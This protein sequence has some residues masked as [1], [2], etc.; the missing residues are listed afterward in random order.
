MLAGND[1]EHI[2]LNVI[3]SSSSHVPC[4][5]SYNIDTD[6]DSSQDTDFP[7]E[8]LV[9]LLDILWGSKCNNKHIDSSI[10][11]LNPL[12]LLE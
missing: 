9:L 6:T 4:P 11:T 8:D 7:Q 5:L 2:Q 10:E 3:L 12:P 1:G